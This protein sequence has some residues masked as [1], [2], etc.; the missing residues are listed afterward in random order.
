MKL[1]FGSQSRFLLVFYNLYLNVRKLNPE[2]TGAVFFVSDSEFF[3][4]NSECLLVEQDTDVILLKEWNYTSRK[5][6][7]KAQ[8]R[9]SFYLEKYKE[10]NLQDAILCDRRL[11]NGGYSKL[12]QN[13]KGRYNDDE[14]RNIIIGALVDIEKKLKDENAI[15]ITPSPACFGDYLLYLWSKKHKQ[16]YFQLKF[17]KIKNY[18]CFSRT[19]DGTTPIEIQKQI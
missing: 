15:I 6:R 8:P 10:Y 4:K 11:I 2:V 12:V 1:V 19:F 14:L 7:N 18:I 3:Y 16:K 5:S 9:E 13:Y 17:T